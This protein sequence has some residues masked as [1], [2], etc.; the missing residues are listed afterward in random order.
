M[1]Y[2]ILYEIKNKKRM[3]KIDFWEEIVF[4]R[5]KDAEIQQNYVHFIA[6][7]TAK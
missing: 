1:L 6:L 4:F 3:I 7:T 5:K 2:L